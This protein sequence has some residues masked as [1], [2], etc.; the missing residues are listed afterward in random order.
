M[1]STFKEELSYCKLIQKIA[2]VLIVL[3]VNQYGLAQCNFDD[4]KALKDL[5]SSTNGDN[6]LD[7][8][9]WEL[10]LQNSPPPNCNLNNLFG[11]STNAM[12]RVSKIN[13]YGNNLS[14]SL[15]NSLG[16]LSALTE[17][18]LGYDPIIGTIPN[19]IGNLTELR[20]LSITDCEIEGAIPTTIN[21]LQNLELLYLFNNQLSGTIPA[22][23]DDLTKLEILFLQNNQLSG[24][25]PAALAN[26][27]SLNRLYISGN[28]LT[29]CY[30]SNWETLCNQLT[31]GLISE[32][33]NLDATWADFCESQAGSCPT[34]NLSNV[35]PGD[36]NFD[37]IVN[38]VDLMHL[39][40][41]LYQSSNSNLNG[42][43]DW[44][45]YER[46]NWATN[47]HADFC[48]YGNDDLKHADC[49]GNGTIDSLDYEVIVKNWNQ[50]HP[51]APFIQPVVPCFFFDDFSDY[52]ISL[53]PTQVIN[54]NFIVFD[55]AVSN[56]ST[57]VKI[58]SG[59]LRI[60]YF[61]TDEPSLLDANITL[62]NS[63]FGN[64]NQ[65]IWYND[66]FNAAEQ[67]VEAGFTKTDLNNSLGQGV[68]GQ[69]AFLF[70]E[71]ETSIAN[72]VVDFNIELGFQNSD[73]TSVFL[74]ENFKINLGEIVCENNLILTD[75]TALQSEYSCNN[76]LTTQG[77]LT[78][79][80]AQN[81]SYKAGETVVLNQGFW[82]E[83]GA[84]FEALNAS[85]D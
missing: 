5:H 10:T 67:S 35:W 2:T 47:Q 13:L 57:P 48:Y 78:I 79:H 68:I 58:R 33:N 50:S 38:G 52:S 85:C 42:G 53:L 69:V 26:I 59:F 28:Q 81:I 66:V 75:Q 83:A 22:N 56:N 44:Q 11:I 62:I 17:L 40:N 82:V 19:E 1:K 46:P 9:N 32:G 41:Y 84:T 7:K 55:I 8:T 60:N 70:N 76:T 54:S 80:Q 43:M 34:V 37:G 74:R 73:T 65:N 27:N 14:G 61:N 20:V 16:L 51:D 29:G 25:L 30:P 12:G 71:Y 23:L 3:I 39:G 4:W 24:T 63:W 15:P 36:V 21:N 77:D 49:D 72:N 18:F 45:A 64:P 31:F 6:W